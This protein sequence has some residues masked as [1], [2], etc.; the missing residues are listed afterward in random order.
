MKKLLILTAVL[1]S[2]TSMA[3]SRVDTVITVD[4]V[5]GMCE[6]RIEKAALELPGVWVADWDMNT[7][8]LRLVYRPKKVSLEEISAALNGV[9][10]DTEIS[11]ASDE[12]YGGIHGCCRYRDEEVVQEHQ[13]N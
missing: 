3:Q 1:W 2:T 12:Q 5:C 10:H 9:G 6:T 8:E 11:K 4:G 13:K 7:H